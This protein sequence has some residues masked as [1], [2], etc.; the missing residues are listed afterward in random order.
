MHPFQELGNRKLQEEL[1]KGL[2]RSLACPESDRE[3]KHN[4][5][6]FE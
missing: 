1:Q 5:Y 2:F 4:D 3:W 6:E